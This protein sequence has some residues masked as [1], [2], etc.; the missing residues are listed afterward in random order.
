[1]QTLAYQQFHWA[2]RH[3][4]IFDVVK[5]NWVLLSPQHNMPFTTIDFGDRKELEPIGQVKWLG[6]TFDNRLKFKQ[7][8][9]NV[10]A[11]GQQRASFL[12]SLSHSHWG[13]PPHLMKTLLTTTIHAAIDY[14]IAA[15]MPLKIPKYFTE[16]LSI[17]DHICARATLGALKTTPS[18]FLDH[19][20]GLTTPRIRL[21]AKILKYIAKVLTKTQH[22]PAHGFAAQAR[23]S[24]PKSH[25]TPYHRFFQHKLCKEYDKYTA[26]TTLDPTVTLRRPL[27]YTTLLR[28]SEERAKAEAKHLKPS[29]H[30]V[31]IYTDRSR[32]PKENTA[33]AA[34]SQGLNK[35]TTEGLDPARSYGIYKAE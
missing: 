13:I 31:I 29:K 14:G 3:G 19:D 30:H 18:L 8:H 7:Q 10:L 5:S 23:S 28:T 27:N 11:K 16:K 1:M 15:W 24:N 4:A 2:K 33:A 26:Q 20:L 9:L 25:H 35:S 32:L 17:I 34:W 12:A 6:I 21:Q 22:H